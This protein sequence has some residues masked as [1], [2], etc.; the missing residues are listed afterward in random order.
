[1]AF[2]LLPRAQD[3]SG[4]VRDFDLLGTALLGATTFSL[5]LPFVLT[6]GTETD[7]PARWWWLLAALGAGSL[8]VIWEKAYLARGKVAIIDFEL[9][10]ISSFRN[11]ILISSFY[12]AA[13]PATFIVLTLFLQRGLGFSP[14]VAGMVTIPFALVSAYTSYRSGKVVH[15]RGRPLVVVG[16]LA[17][18]AGFGLVVLASVTIPDAYMPWAVAVAM[19][20]A[21]A[22]G[23][24]V[25]SPNQTL[26]LEDIPVHQGG[27]AGSL[28]QV[29]QRIGTAIGLAAALSVFFYVLADEANEPLSVAYHDAFAIALTVVVGL[30]AL[31]LVFALLDTKVREMASPPSS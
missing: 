24:A 2:R 26:M 15:K 31:A 6:T 22:G 21:G 16:L 28:A 17:V 20:L 5:M 25:I 12:F 19:T 23:G 10:A 29:G 3:N 11:G 1:M 4:A 9:F 7:N 18:L 8:F 30:V 27:L 13:L 14:V